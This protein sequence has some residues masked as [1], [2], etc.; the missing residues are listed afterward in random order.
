MV[1][2]DYH[3]NP[4][5]IRAADMLSIIEAAHMLY[6]QKVFPKKKQTWRNIADAK[7]IKYNFNWIILARCQENNNTR[8]VEKYKVAT[9]AITPDNIE[10][11]WQKLNGKYTHTQ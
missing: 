2:F 4:L 6:H 3:A 5:D 9:T 8:I 11:W 7:K 10:W 1:A